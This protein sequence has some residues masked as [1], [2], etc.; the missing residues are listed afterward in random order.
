MGFTA[1]IDT[2]IGTTVGLFR[3]RLTAS[4]SGP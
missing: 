1:F 3:A 2:A 4:G